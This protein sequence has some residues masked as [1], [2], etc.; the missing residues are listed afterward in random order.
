MVWGS[1]SDQAANSWLFM[2]Q[3]VYPSAFLKAA[4]L[5]FSNMTLVSAWNSGL[6]DGP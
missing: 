5:Q 4:L 2:H 3:Q 6:R 1:G